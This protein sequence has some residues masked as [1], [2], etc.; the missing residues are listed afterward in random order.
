MGSIASLDAPINA[1]DMTKQL[2]KH[3]GAL[4]WSDN[5]VNK[6]G[7]GTGILISVNLVLTCAHNIYDL[8]S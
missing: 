5:R 3:I 1:K 6:L 8:K 2:H 4:T 7:K